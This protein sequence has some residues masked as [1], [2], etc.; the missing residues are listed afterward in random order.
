MSSLL[1]LFSKI[2]EAEDFSDCA[3]APLA[4][5]YGLGGAENSR[6]GVVDRSGS[7]TF[8]C[9]AGDAMIRKFK[10][11]YHLL[12]AVFWT[13][14][15]GYPAKK[16]YVIGVTGT[17]GKT[18][19]CTLIYE[20]LKAAGIKAGLL[21]T[22]A[23]VIGNEEIET[24][25]HTTNPD[26]SLLQPILKKAAGQGATHMVLEDSHGLDRTGFGAGNFKSEADQH[27]P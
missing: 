8:W 19:T 4:A 17:D 25:L 3:A 22:V 18:T 24:G 27:Y 14:R 13:Y 20:I 10:N 9:L 6:P 16:L 26:P 15:C 11:L 23:A 12:N 5:A 2:Y 7:G 1:Q 21:T